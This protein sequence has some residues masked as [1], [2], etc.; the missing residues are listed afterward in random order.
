MSWQKLRHTAAEVSESVPVWSEVPEEYTVR[1]PSLVD[2]PETYTVKVPQ[3]KDETFEYTVMVP[4][5]VTEKK[6][7]TVTN[8]VPVTKTR[9]I[10]VCVPTTTIQRCST[11]ERF[12]L[13]RITCAAG[14]LVGR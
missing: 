13:E 7:H 4:H 11:D 3:L 6:V 12:I 5:A 10:E 2:V 9:T 14:F 1:V 8:A